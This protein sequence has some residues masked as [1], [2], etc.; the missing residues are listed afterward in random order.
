MP[1]L[2]GAPAK[3]LLAWYRANRRNLPW[4]SEPTPYRVWVSE[5][6]LQQ[7][8]VATVLGH[9]RRWMDHFPT[10]EALAAAPELDVLAAWQGLGYYRRARQLH[11]GARKVVAAGIWPRNA[12]EWRE[13]PGVGPY[14]AG[15]IASIAHG[16][17]AALVDGNVERVYAR[18]NA[19]DA[20][21]PELNRRAWA[22]AKASVHVS[23]PGDWNQALMELGA[24]TCRPV[25]PTCGECPVQAACQAF[26]EGRPTD[27]PRPKPK[28]EV[29]ALEHFIYVPVCGGQVGIRPVPD[30]RWW[31]GM[32][33]FPREQAAS[34]LDEI[35][36]EG[37]ITPLGRFR[38]TVTRHRIL[39][40]VSLCRLAKPQAGLTWILPEQLENY[41][42]PSPQR[43][44]WRLAQASATGK[45]K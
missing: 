12:A 4:R 13:I 28:P 16:E 15:A 1:P 44:A 31:S 25:N 6:M 41:P 2:S 43:R 26:A 37:R 21:G 22:W 18:L 8:Q 7:T 39:V 34:L 45:V 14:T 42:L 17:P 36:G 40:H 11:I 10:V 5:I 19:D 30:G 24:T 27:F 9:Y 35:L 23:V 3:S 29:I 32:W 38:H 20:V 33:E